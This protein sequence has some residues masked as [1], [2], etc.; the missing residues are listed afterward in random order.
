MKLVQLNHLEG[1]FGNLPQDKMKEF[2]SA[3]GE[4]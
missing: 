1:G 4:I 2:A 3:N